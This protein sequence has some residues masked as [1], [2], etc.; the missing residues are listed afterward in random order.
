MGDPLMVAR[1]T[2]QQKATQAFQGIQQKLQQGAVQDMEKKQ[3][4]QQV[5]AQFLRDQPLDFKTREQLAM[6]MG[7][8]LPEPDSGELDRR[9]DRQFDQQSRLMNQRTQGMGLLKPAQR[10]GL[11]SKANSDFNRN[12]KDAQT[13]LGNLDGINR[14]WGEFQKS[15]DPAKLRAAMEQVVVGM[16]GKTVDPLSAVREGEYARTF[17]LAPA[18]DRFNALFGRVMA[19]GQVPLSTLQGLV[20][21]ANEIAKPAQSYMASERDRI[22]ASLPESI[23]PDEVFGKA[24][25]GMHVTPM[26]GTEESATNIAVPAGKH[27]GKPIPLGTVVPGKGTLTGVDANG[28]PVFTK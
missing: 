6:Q 21:T 25:R 18:V 1:T 2:P 7:Q 19:G 23:T 3:E 26:A 14:A 12:T 28:M 13:V 8:P 22:V 5:L 10:Y 4:Y 27:Q 15:N 20:E 9:Q 11:V 17:G 24:Q 16:F